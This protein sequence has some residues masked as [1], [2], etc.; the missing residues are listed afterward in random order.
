M[1]G[2]QKQHEK[3]LVRS[4]GVMNML[5]GEC[6]SNRVVADG[7]VIVLCTASVLHALEYQSGMET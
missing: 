6:R 2:P 7:W 4:N 3:V 5:Y 1:G